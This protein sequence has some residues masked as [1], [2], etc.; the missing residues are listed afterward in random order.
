[1]ATRPSLTTQITAVE[2]ALRALQNLAS[3]IMRGSERKLLMEHLDA[4]RVSLE[5]VQA[6][7][8]DIREFV[9]S[10]KQGG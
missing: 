2:T 8:A 1:M 3:N 9:A 6:N 10:R 4:V 5:W 7:L